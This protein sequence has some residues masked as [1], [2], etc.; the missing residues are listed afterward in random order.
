MSLP[1]LGRNL[2]TEELTAATPAELAGQVDDWF[3]NAGERQVVQVDWL[4]R[5]GYSERIEDGEEMEWDTQDPQWVA[6]IIY[7]E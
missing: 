3:Q 7:T 1:M 6:F 4:V 2:R 5:G